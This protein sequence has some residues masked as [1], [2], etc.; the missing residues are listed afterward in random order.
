MTNLYGIP[1]IEDPNLTKVVEVERQRSWRERLW[2]WPW[3]PW[4]KTKIVEEIHAD[5]DTVYLVNTEVAFRNFVVRGIRRP[6][7]TFVMHPGA[8]GKLKRNS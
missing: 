1:V 3:C 8:V 7:E 5:L 2:S 4:V 6:S